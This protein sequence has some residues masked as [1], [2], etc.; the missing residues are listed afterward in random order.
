MKRLLAYLFIVLGLGLTFSVS[1]HAKY[2]FM[3][4]KDDFN[5]KHF[6]NLDDFIYAQY[7]FDKEKYTK[8]FHDIG[9]NSKCEDLTS[10]SIEK[11]GINIF[12]I[13]I[14]DYG[15]DSALYKKL[16][17]Y[18]KKKKE[19]KYFSPTDNFPSLWA[20]LNSLFASIPSLTAF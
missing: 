19:I 15:K 14:G 2:L 17:K 10:H 6:K 5:L 7:S 9:K 11:Y 13:C 18:S 20:S 12:Q 8:M 4:T 1:A 3:I 16:I